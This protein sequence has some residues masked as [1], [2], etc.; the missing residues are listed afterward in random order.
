MVAEPA[1]RAAAAPMLAYTALFV[2]LYA[3]FGAQSPYLPALLRQRGLDP[4][5]IGT[6]LAAGTAIRLAAAPWAGRLAD[7]LDATRAVFAMCA[8]TAA[9]T[10]L[11]YAVAGGLAALVGVMLLQAAALAPLAQLADALVLRTAASHRR[12]LAYGWVRGAGS[13]AFIC[14][15]VLAGQSIAHYGQAAMIWLAAGLLALA[16]GCAPWLPLLAIPAAPT[17]TASQRGGI[18]ALLRLAAFRRVVAV[19]ALILGSHA[20]HDGF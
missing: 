5:E 16:A 15:T 12:G 6:A 20:M 14:G 19:A 1:G 4:A 11:G 3:G 10:A 7:R 9:F 18:A 2:L 13:A 17:R 8:G